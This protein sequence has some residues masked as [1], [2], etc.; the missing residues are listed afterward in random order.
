MALEPKFQQ[1][2]KSDYSFWAWLTQLLAATVGP[3]VFWGAL[4]S[5]L[6]LRDTLPVQLSGYACRASLSIGLAIA[7]SR[8][9]HWAKTGTWI[10]VLPFLAESWLIYWVISHGERVGTLF[11]ITEGEEGWGLLITWPVWNCCWYSAT[12]WLLLHR[13]WHHLTAPETK[14]SAYP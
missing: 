4:Q 1:I 3:I 7:V 11:L 9:N 5:V 13:R 2:A 8:A 6:H 12:M 10:W 14:R